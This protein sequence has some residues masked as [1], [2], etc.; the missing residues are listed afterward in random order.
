MIISFSGKKLKIYHKDIISIIQTLILYIKG[1]E[2][3]RNTEMERKKQQMRQDVKLL[4][5]KENKYII[6]ADIKSKNE[7]IS[8]EEQRCESIKSFSSDESRS[9]ELVIERR[10]GYGNWKLLK[11][12]QKKEMIMPIRFEFIINV[13]T[14]F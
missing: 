1:T 7:E 5:L 11:M 14:Y 3:R 8:R 4:N 10:E 6:E 9:P 13:L 12:K 2:N